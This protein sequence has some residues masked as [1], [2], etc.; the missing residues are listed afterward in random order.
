MSGLACEGSDSQEILK[1]TKEF[2]ETLCPPLAK[3]TIKGYHNDSTLKIV[4]LDMFLP[5][6]YQGKSLEPDKLSDVTF[7]SMV[8]HNIDK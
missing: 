8:N 7:I 1:D 4:P 3:V 6:I 2:K 5:K